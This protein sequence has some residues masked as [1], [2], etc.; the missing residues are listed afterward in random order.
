MR[1]PD[2]K[3]ELLAPA[4]SYETLCAVIEAGCDA[5]YIGGPRFGAR[6]YAD[7]P[8][9]ELLLRGIGHAHMRGVKVY[10]TVNTVLKQTELGELDSY[11]LPFYEISLLSI[12]CFFDIHAWSWNIFLYISSLK[13]T[14]NLSKFSYQSESIGISFTSYNFTVAPFSIYNFFSSSLICCIVSP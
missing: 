5:V 3:I 11:L 14:F 10:L 6:A 8:D 12:Q 7:N 13:P 1:D 2:G 4:G 9:E